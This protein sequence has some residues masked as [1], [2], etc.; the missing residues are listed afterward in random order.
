MSFFGGSRTATTSGT[1]ARST[2]A[3]PWPLTSTR[4]PPRAASASCSTTSASMPSGSSR[5]DVPLGGGLEGPR[6][7]RDH[8]GLSEEIRPR[9]R[10]FTTASRK[11]LIGCATTLSGV[12]HP[13]SRSGCT[14]RR[15]ASWSPPRHRHRRSVE[16]DVR[17]ATSARGAGSCWPNVSSPTPRRLATSCNSPRAWRRRSLHY[18]SVSAF[19]RCF[20]SEPTTWP[21][22]SSVTRTTPPAA[23]PS[24]A[25]ARRTPRAPSP[26]KDALSGHPQ[27][28][29][30]S[31]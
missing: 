6:R 10:L 22:S 20:L 17:G 7:R 9:Y 28:P 11:R 12:A 19:G 2:T 14:C 24:V 8:Q 31:A 26:S 21:R 15:A 4:R 27:S 3:S 5:E 25:G 16:G 1:S 29:R 23:L 18:R 30:R 13:M